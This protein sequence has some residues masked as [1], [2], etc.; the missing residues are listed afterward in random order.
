MH[1]RSL[2][3]EWHDILVKLHNKLACILGYKKDNVLQNNND[4]PIII[5]L[6]RNKDKVT[7]NPRHLF[8]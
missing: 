4:E 6:L 7:S 5:A 3:T 1:L 2:P 8:E